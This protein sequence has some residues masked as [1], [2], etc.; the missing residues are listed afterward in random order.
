L[1]AL[2]QICTNGLYYDS[3][4]RLCKQCDLGKHCSQYSLNNP[5]NA[6][7]GS[8]SGTQYCPKGT[9]T[10]DIVTCPA[11]LKC[12]DHTYTICN[13]GKMLSGVSS[14]SCIDC[15][16]GNYCTLRADNLKQAVSAGYYSLVGV[17]VQ[18]ICPGGKLCS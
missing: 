10:S 14:G 7:A 16:A 18:L 1:N 8:C 2:G 13:D 3:A 4:T 11:Y 12:S 17:S 15:P 5:V 6:V 9:L